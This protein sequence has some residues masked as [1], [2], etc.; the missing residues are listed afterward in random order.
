[1]RGGSLYDQFLNKFLV[2]YE[3]KGEDKRKEY[4]M[5]FPV[6]IGRDGKMFF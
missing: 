6:T 4:K 1:M 3:G 5:L 2:N